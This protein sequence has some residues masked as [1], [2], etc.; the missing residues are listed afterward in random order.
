MRHPHGVD[1]CRFWDWYRTCRKP[2]AFWTSSWRPGGMPGQLE[3]HWMIRCEHSIVN[4]IQSVTQLTPQQQPTDLEKGQGVGLL[5]L[6]L[7]F[8]VSSYDSWI[9]IIHIDADGGTLNLG[10]MGPRKRGWW[11]QET[12]GI[13]FSCGS[14]SEKPAVGK[15]ISLLWFLLP[16]PKIFQGPWQ[17]NTR[18]RCPPFSLSQILCKCS[19]KFKYHKQDCY[20]N[21]PTD[22]PEEVFQDLDPKG[23]KKVPATQNEVPAQWDVSAPS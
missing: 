7:C 5:S 14:S 22:S 21:S 3:G 12:R 19:N 11:S 1:R 9:C 8:C 6:R 16:S 20:S 18:E 4:E 17:E 10:L 13:P 23:S 15:C 2:K